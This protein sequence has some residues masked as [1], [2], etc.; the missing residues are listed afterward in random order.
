ML[1]SVSVLAAAMPDLS[2]FQ[3]SVVDNIFSITVATMGA[4]AVWW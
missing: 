2:I 3:Y 4:A 1:E